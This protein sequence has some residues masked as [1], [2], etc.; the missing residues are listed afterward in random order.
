[1]DSAKRKKAEQIFAQVLDTIKP[2]D[3]E[4]REITYNS[5]R[6]MG[7][8]KE[9]I[10]KD[11]E[12]RVVGSI[13]RA[14]N[15]K[16]TADLD[17]FML[18]DKKISKDAIVKKGLAYAKSLSKRI[19]NTRCEIK[20][21][22]HPYARLYFND[23]GIKLDLVPAY[24]LEKIEDKGTAVDRTPLHT[25]FINKNL[26]ARQRDEV[27]LMKYLLRTHNIYGAEVKVKGF[28]GY[29]CEL[30]IY[31]FGSLLGVIEFFAH[32][33]LPI[34]INPMQK[35]V[36]PD[37][38]LRKKF[39][40]DFIVIDPVD[41]NRNVSA[42]VSID[43]LAKFS[44]IAKMFL[45]KPMIEMF[46]GH[47]TDIADA[48]KLFDQFVKSTNSEY[49]LV[50]IPIADK[51]DDVIWPQL[52]KLSDIIRERIEKE[53]FAITLSASW[54]SERIGKILYLSPKAEL[55]A[56][57]IKG[58]SGFGGDY[59]LK[60]I[61][62]HNKAHGFVFKNGSIHAF[63]ETEYK[64][65]GEVIVSIMK[66]RSKIKNPD[67]KLPAYKLV[68]KLDIQDSKEAYQNLAERLRV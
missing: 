35:S 3:V 23:L 1:M 50:K 19:G 52:N 40:S 38:K 27:R 51:T 22:E 30:L 53:G 34:C 59:A 18:F 42:I 9:I 49:Y 58:P 33:K 25:D 64:N 10:D 4:V 28:S 48:V 55:K 65:V 15:L 16:G 29:L 6:M 11:V 62:A 37:E 24:K 31:N 44:I 13:A 39:N 46:Y 5:N 32:A 67:L 36:A 14:T 57:L 26:T 2:S 8:L 56:R 60:F 45:E 20:Y 54:V 12:I 17:I 63:E 61:K 41:P 7:A 43:S 68:K 21:A 66:E 47:G